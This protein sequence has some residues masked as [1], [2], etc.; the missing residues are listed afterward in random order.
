MGPEI[1]ELGQN[2]RGCLAMA[3]NVDK[4]GFVSSTAEV[5]GGGRGGKRLSDLVLEIWEEL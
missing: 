5:A 1:E 3:V 2:L 4:V